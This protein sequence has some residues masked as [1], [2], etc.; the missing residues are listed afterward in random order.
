MTDDYR[1]HEI[2]DGLQKYMDDDVFDSFK[3]SGPLVMSQELVDA[4]HAVLDKDERERSLSPL[5]RETAEIE[6]AIIEREG[7]ATPLPNDEWGQW[8]W[9]D[10]YKA[11][12]N[13]RVEILSK[14]NARR[15][16]SGLW[17]SRQR[18]L[19][20]LHHLLECAGR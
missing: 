6:L 5:I 19:E 17:A 10:F 2:F 18:Q 7:V 4:L 3:K 20:E 12:R 9:G 16:E 15:H 1:L 11:D 14:W 13:R 8:K